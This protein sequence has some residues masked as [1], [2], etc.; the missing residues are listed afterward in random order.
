MHPNQH[1]SLRFFL[2]IVSLWFKAY[3][4]F[5]L[6]SILSG[7]FVS[8]III[9]ALMDV[10]PTALQPCILASYSPSCSSPTPPKNV[11]LSQ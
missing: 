6:S 7:P 3:G 2:S 5:I 4:Q 11:F 1:S 10:L 9:T 8:L